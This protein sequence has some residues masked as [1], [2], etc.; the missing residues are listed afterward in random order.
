L[1][2]SVSS[3][4][5]DIVDSFKEGEAA[6]DKKT[7]ARAVGDGVTDED[8]AGEAAGRGDEPAGIAIGVA[9]G[10]SKF[11]AVA[12]GFGGSEEL[13]ATGVGD[14]D[15]PGLIPEF[16]IIPSPGTYTGPSICESKIRRID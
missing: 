12:T 11:E 1:S 6:I 2:R 16:A 5:N 4:P 8:G 3:E 13:L 15:C 14:G 7:D 9:D 10:A